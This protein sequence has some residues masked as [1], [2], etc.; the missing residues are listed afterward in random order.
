MELVE[1]KYEQGIVD[2]FT[3][4]MISVIMGLNVKETFIWGADYF[5]EYIPNKIKMKVVG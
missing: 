3:P 5:A 2:E 1:K 4:E